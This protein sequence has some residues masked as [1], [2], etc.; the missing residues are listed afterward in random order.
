MFLGVIAAVVLGLAQTPG[1]GPGRILVDGKVNPEQVPDWILWNQIFTMAAYLDNKSTS[2]G[3][4][5][6]VDKL[7][8]PKDVMKEVVNHGYEQLEMADDVN[9]EANDLVAD[10]KKAR[11]EKI[12]HPDRKE[13]LRIKLKQSQLQMEA[14]TLEI[15]DKLRRRVGDDSYLRLE[16]YARLQIA[17]TI[18]IGN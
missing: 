14:R 6:W 11:P 3:E 1:K 2:H 5:L 18:K 9:K 16:S 8:L 4:E 12:D 13:G 17:P 10:S 15:R 7:H